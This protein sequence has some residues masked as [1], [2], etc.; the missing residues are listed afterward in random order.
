MVCARAS[1]LV[2]AV[3]SITVNRETAVLQPRFRL[4]ALG[5]VICTVACSKSSAASTST[6][7]A[8]PATASTTD[9]GNGATASVIDCKKVFTPSDVAGIFVAPATVSADTMFFCGGCEFETAKGAGID[10]SVSGGNDARSPG[11]TSARRPTASA[12][13]HRFGDAASCCAGSECVRI[14]LR[15]EGNAYQL[16]LQ[17]PRR[18]RTTTA[19]YASG[20]GEATGRALHQGFRGD[21]IT[22]VA[23]G[24]WR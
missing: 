24:Q 10:V 23:P 8:G 15:Q 3:R 7:D 4:M 11:T 14:V 5:C 6:H 21:V 16:Q 20:I 17:H 22:A 19:S 9:A 12:T 1:T 18:C 13:L 2:L